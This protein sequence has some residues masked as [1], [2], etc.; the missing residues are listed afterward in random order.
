MTSPCRSCV[1]V[2]TPSSSVPA[3]SLSSLISTSRIFVPCPSVSKSN[4][5]AIG[6]SV[7]QWPTFLIPSLRRISA[8]TSCEV[9]PSALST[10]RTPSG[11]GFKDFINFLQDFLF[12][13]SERPA[14]ARARR[15][16]M[17]ATA[18]LLADGTNVDGIAFRT[19]AD[20]HLAVGQFFE[21]DG[22]DHT[23]NRAE[24]VDQPFVVFGKNA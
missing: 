22:N 8:T 15:E 7:P 3:Y 20:A 21:E 5:V 17:S 9:I 16:S 4:P 14:Y 1:L 19:H 6:S 10:S 12:D 2:V 24:M 23:A 13:F 18:K 11:V